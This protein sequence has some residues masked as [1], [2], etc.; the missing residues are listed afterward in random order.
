MLIAVLHHSAPEGQV[1]VRV[2][3]VHLVLDH[4]LDVANGV[5]PGDIKDDGPATCWCL[6]EDLVLDVAGLGL[7][8]ADIRLLVDDGAAL[9]GCRVIVAVVVVLVLLRDDGLQLDDA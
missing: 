1:E 9:G 6:R 2:V 3:G 8:V 5:V 4:E 7:V